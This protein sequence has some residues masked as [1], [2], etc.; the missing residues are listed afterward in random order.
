M[1][2]LADDKSRSYELGPEGDY[3]VVA[4]DVIYEGA[5]VG[6]S[7]GYARPL[8][9]GDR[10]LGFA[11][12]KADNA[13]GAAGAIYVHVRRAGRVQLAISGLVITDLGLP[14]YASDDDTYS[15]SPVGGSYIGRVARYVASG[16][17][18]VA[19]DL[20]GDRDPWSGWTWETVS[21]DKT[22]DQEDVGKAFWVTVDAKAVTLPALAAN[23]VLV[24]NGAA[25]G[26]VAVTVSP[27]ASDGIA[28]PDMSSADDKDIVNTKATARR[29][30]YVALE[31]G[32]ANDWMVT[33]KRGTWAK[34]S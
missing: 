31:Y 20:D 33:A 4:A 27:N 10:F 19:F 34:Q 29:G 13:A 30:D 23:R 15:L 7:A 21:D 25:D 28:A 32:D 5:A 26:T 8:V 17:G 16:V 14:V 12:A 9:G 11:L 2:T 22:L 1:T 6:E 18:V 3:P 24:M